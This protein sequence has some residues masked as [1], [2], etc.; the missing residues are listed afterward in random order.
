MSLSDCPQ[1]ILEIIIN[2]LDLDFCLTVLCQVNKS[3]Y[4]YCKDPNSIIW[5]KLLLKHMPCIH[6]NTDLVQYAPKSR[7]DKWKILN[8]SEYW[9]AMK[10]RTKSLNFMYSTFKDT[11][12]SGYGFTKCDL[13][14]ANFKSADLTRTIFVNTIKMT[15]CNMRDA[16]LYHTNLRG[17]Y[18]S[19][20]NFTEAQITNTNFNQA[21]LLNT[22][23]INTNIQN[24]SYNET[25]L[26]NANFTG[27]ILFETSFKDSNLSNAK[28]INANVSNTSYNACI[29][30]MTDFTNATISKTSFKFADLKYVKFINVN[31]NNIVYND[32]S[33]H[34]ADF[35]NAIIYY[36]NI[37]G[38]QLTNINV[39]DANI[40]GTSGA[41]IDFRF[42]V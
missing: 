29:L 17:A 35:T 20:S 38:A 16:V 22:I 9:L 30:N 23:F 25:T 10:T 7:R 27:A 13:Y 37:S 24:T 18:L 2:I 41:R 34:N 31:G 11:N 15:K 1:E 42:V 40:Y 33:L 3:L 21:I 28:F 5:E 14:Q 39:T 12:L 26:L 6:I 36:A 32:A 19:D 8:S 4:Q